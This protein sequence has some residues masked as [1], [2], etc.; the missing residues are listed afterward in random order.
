VPTIIQPSH[1][2]SR[3]R[4][5]LV[6]VSAVVLVSVGGFVFYMLSQPK[7]VKVTLASIPAINKQANIHVLQGDIPT[8]L[9]VY[10]EA[11]SRADGTVTAGNLYLQKA[12][13]EFNANKFEGALKDATAANERTPSAG[14]SALIASIYVAQGNH[15]QA[16]KFYHQAA[17]RVKSNRTS[18]ESS[19]YY[20]AQAAREEKS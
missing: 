9:G 6:I 3:L 5:I 12:S 15:A 8:A 7:P 2:G 1:R 20:E 4:L 13:I 14:A 11:I 17:G 16:A 10:D 18:G 19:Q